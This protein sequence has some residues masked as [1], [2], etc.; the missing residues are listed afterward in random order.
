[1]RLGI[2]I[3]GSL[4][5]DPSCPRCRWRQARFGCG[6]ARPVRVPIRYGKKS[7][8]RND[9]YTMVFASSC[10][11]PERLGTGLVVPARAE[12][13]APEHLLEEAEHLWAAERDVE[14]VGG[15]CADWGKVMVKANPALN[16]GNETLQGWRDHVE[17]CGASY[18][19]LPTASNEPAI[20]DHTTGMALFD[21]PMDV[22][23]ETAL[24]GFDLLLMTATKPTL[25]QGQYPTPEEVA[26]AWRAD[27]KGNIVYF[28]NNRQY[29][30]TT[31]EDAQ[32]QALL[33]GGP[34]NKPVAATGAPRR[35]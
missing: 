8:K 26:G 16:P 23:T 25:N 11:V 12:C 22:E 13:C 20:L 10:S 24:V 5:W 28:H 35:R 21:W 15:I 33:A 34:P 30:I 32:I 9:T 6:E 19:A 7:K 4:F 1:M 27:V 14:T 18:T 2:L 29:G 17:S 3:I 31:F